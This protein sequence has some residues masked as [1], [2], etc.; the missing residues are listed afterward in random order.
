MAVDLARIVEHADKQGQLHSEKVRKHLIFTD[1][2]IGGEGDGPLSPSPVHMGLVGFSDN[3]VLGDYLNCLSMG[4]TPE[5]I[6]MI[7]E[8]LKLEEYA[9]ASADA[10]RTPVRLNGQEVTVGEYRKRFS[11]KF[12]PPSEWVASL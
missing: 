2:V 4:Y 9:L 12:R 5:S 3:V 8:A 6:P 7:R 10:V 11:R 1:G